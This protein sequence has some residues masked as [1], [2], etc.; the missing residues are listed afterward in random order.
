MM[1]I[2]IKNLDTGK[3]LYFKARTPYDGMLQLKY[4]LSISNKSA[5][6]SVINKI[7]SN[8]FLYLIFNDETYSTKI[9]DLGGQTND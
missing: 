7:E 9:D 2:P 6:K 8:H 4:Y 5:E 1:L 3:M